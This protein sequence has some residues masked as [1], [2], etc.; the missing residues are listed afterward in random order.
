MAYDKINPDWIRTGVNNDAVEWAK[1]FGEFLTQGGR[2]S[3][4]STSQ[5]RKFFGELKRIQ[6]DYDKLKTEL[7]MLKAQLA[8]AVG[9]KPDTKIK[10]FNEEIS[11]ALDSVR[12]NNKSDFN[13]F[14]KIAEAIVAYHK[15]FGGND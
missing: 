11:I 14:V 6:A 12:E 7:P 5:I 9:R 2:K 10:Q 1:S 3:S 13:N 8:Y 4:L 15:F